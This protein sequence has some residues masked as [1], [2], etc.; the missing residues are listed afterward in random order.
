VSPDKL[1]AIGINQI[2]KQEASS[3]PVKPKP[4]K[5]V[6]EKPIS[7]GLDILKLFECDDNEDYNKLVKSSLEYFGKT[8]TNT[9]MQ[10]L[11]M[12]AIVNNPKAVA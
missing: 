5:K 1:N 3:L 11:I 10:K 4:I 8:K 12:T 6:E 2:Q 7:S 9:D